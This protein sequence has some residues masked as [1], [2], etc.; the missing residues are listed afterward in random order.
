[1]EL[2]HVHV[3]LVKNELIPGSFLMEENIFP[4]SDEKIKNIHFHVICYLILNLLSDP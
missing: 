4:S 1:M 2:V 3:R